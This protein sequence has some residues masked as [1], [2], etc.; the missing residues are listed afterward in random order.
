[1]QSLSL[2]AHSPASPPQAPVHL[3]SPEAVFHRDSNDRRPPPPPGLHPEIVEATLEAVAA[4]QGI[5]VAVESSPA[6]FCDLHLA[7][8]G[9]ICPDP[10]VAMTQIGEAIASLTHSRQ[11]EA[12]KNQFQALSQTSETPQS[13]RISFSGESPDGTASWIGFIA[14]EAFEPPAQSV[15]LLRSVDEIEPFITEHSSWFTPHV[16]QTPR[17][18][19]FAKRSQQLCIRETAQAIALLLRPQEQLLDVLPVRYQRKTSCLV[20][21]EQ[22]LLC[23]RQ[24]LFRQE[25]T[26]QLD[27][28]LIDISYIA[29]AP[30]GMVIHQFDS[31]SHLSP[32]SQPHNEYQLYFST[33]DL[34][35]LEI[36]LSYFTRV[37]RCNVL[38]E[39]ALNPKLSR[40][41]LSRA[42]Q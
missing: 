12:S 25:A 37:V 17:L 30:N 38:P 39:T 32:S 3:T 15:S 42:H 40:A 24:A 26:L 4:E 22:R 21:T 16:R 6:S 7:L 8:S 29:L 13:E 11:Q 34:N 10:L 14:L 1:M 9:E 27:L 36:L 28:A 18:H 23:L 41:Q 2:Q 35:S 31:Q 20:L 5:S 19:Q 33:A